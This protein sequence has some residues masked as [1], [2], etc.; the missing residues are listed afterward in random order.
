VIVLSLDYKRKKPEEEG[1]NENKTKVI[2]TLSQRNRN[3]R[4][5]FIPGRSWKKTGQSKGDRQIYMEMISKIRQSDKQKTGGSVWESNPPK[6]LLM[7]PN[8]FEVREAH[9]NS[10]APP[11]TIVSD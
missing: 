5:L 11:A 7:P 4:E 3:V 10:D 9:R 6:T 2:T 1:K 8:G